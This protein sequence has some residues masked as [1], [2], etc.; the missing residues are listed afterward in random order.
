MNTQAKS[1]PNLHPAADVR[2]IARGGIAIIALTFGGLGAWAA[3]A[4]LAG[5]IIAPGTVKVETNRKSVQH[6]EGG[7]VKAIL[8]KD[9]DRVRAGQPLIVL[10]D[11]RSD[12]TLAT[13]NLQLAAER[14]RAARLKA[15][16]EGV[17]R[18]AFPAELTA[19]ASEPAIAEVMR[20]EISLFD[21]R[22]R[23]QREQLD[24]IRSQILET[25]QEL[26][27]LQAS[28]QASVSGG[29]ILSEELKANEDLAQR[30]FVSKMQV[31]R[32]QRGMQEYEA[33]RTSTLAEMS[34]AKQKL[35]EL[36]LRANALRNDFRKAAGDELTV[37]QTKI[38][39]LEAQLVPSADAVKR[40]E[41]F[42]PMAGTVVGLRVFTPGGVVAPR[43]V[44]LDIVPEDN[45]LIVEAQLKLDD[46]QHVAIGMPAQIR[47]TAY[48]ARG[49][50]MLD[51]AVT[52]VSAD[53]M[54]DKATG[55]A[56]YVAQV[57]V[58]ASA[59]ANNQAIRLLP[60]MRAEVFLRTGERTAMEYVLEPLTS[61]LRRA[62]REP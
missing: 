29:A 17:T 41:V 31:L 14:S 19:R 43:E 34:K 42:A 50:P 26:A 9:G 1:L 40:Q 58:D 44:L 5:A 24:L 38:A 51:G 56:F 53:K 25:R 46:I 8:V 59:L 2:R 3:L 13:V 37:A 18:V 55:S 10:S 57:K 15:E 20:V 52:Y 48:H 22:A 36:D 61:S 6:L 49:T 32:L 11:S 23:A 4:P 28:A 54:E 12:A 45:P 60:G 7:I 39:S 21:A 16:Y 33:R 62:G 27:N 47:F 35:G 30:G